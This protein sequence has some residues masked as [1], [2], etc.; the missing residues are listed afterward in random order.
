MA[1]LHWAM[2]HNINHPNMRIE[3]P[4]LFQNNNNIGTCD[5]TSFAFNIDQ[6]SLIAWDNTYIM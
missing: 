2:C 1:Y 4:K 5:N 6:N 3:C